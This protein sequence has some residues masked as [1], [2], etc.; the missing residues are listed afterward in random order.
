[1]LIEIILFFW[2]RR[3]RH[4]ERMRIIKKILIFL[5]KHRVNKPYTG[6][7]TQADIYARSA[8]TTWF[9][10][11]VI[12]ESYLLLILFQKTSFDSNALCLAFAI[13]R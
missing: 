6:V 3:K 2:E 4:T 13:H 12:K 5:H 7:V 1:V 10:L 8:N 11:V 9:V